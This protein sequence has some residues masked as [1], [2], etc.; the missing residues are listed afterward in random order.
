L[1]S[2]SNLSLLVLLL[3]SPSVLAIYCKYIAVKRLLKSRKLCV[4]L[5]K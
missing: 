1:N 3:V 5:L 4:L 2:L